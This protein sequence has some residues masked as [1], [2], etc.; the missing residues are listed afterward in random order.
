MES[1]RKLK[2][3]MWKWENL[4]YSYDGMYENRYKGFWKKLQIK[5][6]RNDNKKELKQAVKEY[7]ED[8]C[9]KN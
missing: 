6:I 2:H 9:T 7:K 4:D 8:S 1:R 5:K 3:H